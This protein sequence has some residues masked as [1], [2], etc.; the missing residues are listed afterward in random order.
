MVKID[1]TIESVSHLKWDNQEHSSFTCTV[2]FAEF[3]EA[4]LFT[5]NPNDMYEHT[6][7]IWNKGIRGG[8][9]PV[10]EA[11]IFESSTDI[12]INEE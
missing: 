2:K 10:E 5:A 6:L 3:D 12:E 4:M 11:D 8:Y 1:R 7:A 9:G